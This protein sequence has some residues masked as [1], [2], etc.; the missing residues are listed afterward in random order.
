MVAGD[1]V[2][3]VQPILIT[4]LSYQYAS[5]CNLTTLMGKMHGI[6][7]MKREIDAKLFNAKIPAFLMIDPYKL[8]Y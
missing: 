7:L 6:Y 8:N 1:G 5:G 3:E 4:G 2:I